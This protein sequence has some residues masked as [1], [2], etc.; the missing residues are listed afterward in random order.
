MKTAITARLAYICAVAIVL[1]GCDKEPTGQVVAVVNG[2]EITQQEL[3]AE[4]AELPNPP[5]GDKKAVQR[6]MLQ[7]II[8]RRLMA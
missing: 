3:N 8:N 4:I 2:E 6:Q 7:Q 5:A 1:H